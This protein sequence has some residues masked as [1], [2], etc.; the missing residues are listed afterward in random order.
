MTLSEYAE[1]LGHWQSLKGRL[2][3]RA[4]TLRVRILNHRIRAGIVEVQVSTGE[5]LGKWWVESDRI[6]RA[7]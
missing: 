5:G 6:E 3:G 1:S 2:L 7:D 4:G